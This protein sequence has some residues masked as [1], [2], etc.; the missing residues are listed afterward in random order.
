MQPDQ[1]IDMFSQ[2]GFELAQRIAKAFATSD[3]VPSQFRAF[4]VKKVKSGNDY[5][6]TWVENPAALGNCLVAIET[7]RA[8][9][10]SI[11]SVMQHANIIENRLSWSA[12]FVIAAINA[13]GRFTPLRFDMQE[14]GRIKA[15]YREKQG[16]NKAKGGYDFKDVEV[17]LDDI[18][19]VAWALPRDIS[20]KGIYTLQQARDAKMPVIESAPVS[21]KLAVEE[22]WYGKSGSKW[23]TEMKHL[24]LQYRAG[25]FFGRIH[26]P[27]I[28]MGMGRTTEEIL[29]M[30]TIDMDTMG[31]VTNVR[32]EELRRP[33][34][35]QPEPVIEVVQQNTSD[36]PS[37]DDQGGQPDADGVIGGDAGNPPADDID[38]NALAEQLEKATNQ[39]ALDLVADGIRDVADAESREVLNGIYRRRVDELAAAKAPA[40]QQPTARRA[41]TPVNSP[42]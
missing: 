15:K 34:N 20:T 38:V 23:Q 40:Q 37:T 10:M 1:K 17:E 18:R 28:V 8:V 16:W 30:T 27:D 6:E 5:N 26:A 24:M 35:K 25:T 32:S 41:R 11:T 13:S 31:N 19:C 33:A 29:D 9:G 3:A 22:G 2:R 12:Q 39:E 42:E 36:A 14:R 4:N 7:A 21:M